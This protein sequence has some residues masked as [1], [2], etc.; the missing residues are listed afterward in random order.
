MISFNLV[1]AI[2]IY[3]FCALL[4]DLFIFFINYSFS[5]NEKNRLKRAIETSGSDGWFKYIYI[6]FGIIL[7]VL[8][9]LAL[10]GIISDLFCG[11]CIVVVFGQPVVMMCAIIQIA[12]WRKRKKG[13]KENYFQ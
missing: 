3:L 12:K 4:F 11:L 10:F 2:T 8:Y 6:I 5:K 7:I 1:I 13:I 9:T